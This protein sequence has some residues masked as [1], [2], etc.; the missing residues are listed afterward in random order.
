MARRKQSLAAAPIDLSYAN[1]AALILRAVRH[2]HI[3]LVGCGGNGSWLAPSIARIARVLREADADREVSVVFIDPD[4]VE[5]TNVPRQNFCYAEIGRPK[6]AT[7]AARYGT[8]W[9]LDI[10]AV[11]RRFDPA[12]VRGAYNQLTLLIGCVDNAAARRSLADSLK[13]N[14]WSGDRLPSVWWLDCGNWRDSGQVLLGSAPTAEHL[15]GAF[16][17]LPS[18]CTALPSP[19]LQHPEL[20]QPLPEE[21]AGD[22][23]S[24]AD[25]GV[26]N[27][28]SLVINQRIAAEAADF[29]AHLL[30][31]RDLRRF[32]AYI[33]LAS[34]SARSRYITPDSV[35]VAAGQSPARLLGLQKGRKR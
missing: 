31:S 7:L 21:S 2:L 6:A 33:D 5:E 13:H 18:K 30:L 19:A 15:R 34:G 22:R 1:S 25:L 9:G 8:A 28:Q 11:S 24:C 27:R 12:M 10:S 26:A 20:L 14:S 29:L 4:V 16:A 17:S 23:L 35:A 3:A 32:A